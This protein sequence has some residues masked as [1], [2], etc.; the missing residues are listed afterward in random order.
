MGGYNKNQTLHENNKNGH[1]MG[2]SRG[3]VAADN[4]DKTRKIS[5]L[6]W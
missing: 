3:S 4:F 6:Y 5:V 1:I 2:L